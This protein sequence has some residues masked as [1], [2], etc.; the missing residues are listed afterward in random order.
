[1]GDKSVLRIKPGSKLLRSAVTVWRKT[2]ERGK[3]EENREGDAEGKVS[4]GGL[5]KRNGL[6]KIRRREG[7]RLIEIANVRRKRGRVYPSTPPPT[8]SL[9]RRV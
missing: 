4:Q 7:K 1:M 9:L 3:G 8:H 6:E 2:R 5:V